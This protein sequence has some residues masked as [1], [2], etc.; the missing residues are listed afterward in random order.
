MI[1]KR[2]L[3]FW[4]TVREITQICKYGT[5]LI[6]SVVQIRGGLTPEIVQKALESVYQRHPLLRAKIEKKGDDYFFRFD[7]KFNDIPF[8]VIEKTNAKEW[9]QIIEN[10]LHT[11]LKTHHF[12]WR[13]HF[14]YNKKD[15]D[16]L[17]EVVLALHHAAG[18]G[19][20][21]ISFFNDFLTSCD[22]LMNQKP[23]SLSSLPSMPNVEALLPTQYDWKT[24]YQFLHDHASGKTDP[25]LYEKTEALPLRQTKNFY[26]SLSEKEVKDLHQACQKQGITIN[27]ILS[28]AILLAG[29]SV[30]PQ[31][32]SFS[33]I[34]L[35]DL[36]SR[37]QP[38]ISKEPIGCYVTSL[39]TQ[40]VFNLKNSIWEIAKEYQDQLQAKLPQ[41]L[42]LPNEFSS[43]DLENF[44]V[45]NPTGKPLLDNQFIIDFGITNLG[46][47]DIPKPCRNFQLE[48][49]FFCTSRQA[50]DIGV[51]VNVATIQGK[52]F[53]CLE[54]A[55]PL[56]SPETADKLANQFVFYIK[57]LIR[58]AEID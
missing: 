2:K 21:I 45:A 4:E 23:L 15:P 48:Q 14:L 16:S 3:G 35:V 30:N 49:F 17:H 58:H 47:L 34:T 46:V 1:I 13:I 52:M 19:Y 33:F 36:R 40:H 22:S 32:K 37:C 31:K 56:M 26:Y 39:D 51:F 25:W 38:V 7:C 43:K 41:A 44:S 55:E 42:C 53:I 29:L 18:D 11:P 9:Q 54:H 8:V 24:Y 6:V 12:L 50:G 28:A 57:N 20:S 10:E 5:S 27:S